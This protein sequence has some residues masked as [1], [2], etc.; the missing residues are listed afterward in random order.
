MGVFRPDQGEILRELAAS[1]ER[2]MLA[3]YGVEDAAPARLWHTT[4]PAALPQQAGR[5]RIDPARRGAETKGGAERAEEEG[6]A[7]SAVIQALRHADVRARQ[8]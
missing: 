6:K 1:A 7:V 4:T 2:G 5:R 3:R 8:E